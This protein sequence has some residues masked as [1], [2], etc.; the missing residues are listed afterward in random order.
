MSIENG[1]L[2]KNKSQENQYLFA[3]LRSFAPFARNLQPF[4]F[5]A[6]V[7][8]RRRAAKVGGLA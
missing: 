2:H 8:K 4:K 3:H 5:R 1:A 6:K 7:A